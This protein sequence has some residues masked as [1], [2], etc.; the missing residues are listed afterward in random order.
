MKTVRVYRLRTPVRIAGNTARTNSHISATRPAPV[1]GRISGALDGGHSKCHGTCYAFAIG[2]PSVCHGTCSAS[3]T[4]RPSQ[5]SMGRTAE[6][7]GSVPPG[8]TEGGDLD[9]F[10][11]VNSLCR[12]SGWP[13]P[14]SC[15]G[16]TAR[17]YDTTR[18]A[19]RR[20]SR[21]TSGEVT[22]VRAVAA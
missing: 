10:P 11:Q 3:A 5:P 9:A 16:Y 2:L 19:S 1:A 14:E 12:I 21:V 4:R 15:T 17:R 18:R 7:Y 22:A 13:I 6:R 8:G 20:E